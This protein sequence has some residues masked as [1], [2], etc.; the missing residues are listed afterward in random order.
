MRIA[1]LCND[2]IA[3]PALDQ[4]LATGLVV[5]VGVP[6]GN[7]AI[8]TLIEG[9]CKQVNV[10][11]QEFHKKSMGAELQQW[12]GQYVPDV[13]LV[14]TFP[15]LIP[16]EVIRLPRY[17][18]INF[19]YA[20]LPEWR[21]ANPLFWM[22]RNQETTGAVTVHEMNETYDAG[23]VLLQQPVPLT[24]DVNFGLFYTQ[25]AY[26]GVHVTGMLLNGLLTGTLQKK[27]RTIPGPGGITG[28]HPPTCLLT[29]PSWMRAK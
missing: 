12:I 25:L 9:R 22:I 8:R 24:P 18:F 2:R 4:L 27:N 10:L 1:I 20:P 19:H 7:H 29:G 23:P 15:F 17:G 11:L 6:F 13:V 16:A 3:L 5:A 26:A 21:G 14:K 28:L